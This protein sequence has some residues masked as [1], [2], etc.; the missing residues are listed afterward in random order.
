MHFSRFFAASALAAAVTASPLGVPHAV[1]EKRSELPYGWAKREV[2]DRRAILP[3]K[4]GLT[5]SN[6]DKGWEWLSE[7]SVPTSAKYGK[8]W[9]AKEVAEAFAPSEKTVDAVK[10]WLT[11][12]GIHDSRIKQSQGLNW[13]EFEATVDE[14]EELLKTKYHVY[15]H[16]ESGQPHVACDEYSIPAHLKEHVD[17]V[18]PTVHFDGKIKPRDNT[19]DLETR[20]LVP[21]RHKGPGGPGWPGKPGGGES[22]RIWSP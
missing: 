19:L 6:M 7:V 3:M 22:W 14:A 21:G 4:V 20:E 10:T 8:H 18:Y 5:Q 1:H 17:L 13:L 16:E 15:E 2:L 9:T 12:A 11:S